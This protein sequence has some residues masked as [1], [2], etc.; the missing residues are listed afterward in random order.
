MAALTIIVVLVCSGAWFAN[1]PPP[2]CISNLR[3]RTPH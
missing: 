3:L 1:T 2:P